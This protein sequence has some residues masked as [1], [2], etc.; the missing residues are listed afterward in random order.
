MRNPY[1]VPRKEPP[2]YLSG[3]KVAKVDRVEWLYMPD[4]NTALAALQAG[5]IDYF[6]SPPLDFIQLMKRIRTSR[7]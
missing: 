7:C 3:G 4:N 5:E 6:E 1:Y 2:D